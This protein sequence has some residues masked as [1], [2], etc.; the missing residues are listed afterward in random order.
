MPQLKVGDSA[1]EIKNATLVYTAN[2][3]TAF[4]LSKALTNNESILLAFHR[5]ASCPVCNFSLRQFQHE[6]DNLL[7]MG[8]RYVP[9][10][11]SS[12]E[13]MQEAYSEEPPFAIIAD[14]DM[15]LYKSYGLK[16]SLSAFLHP[17]AIGDGFKAV[18][19]ILQ[20]GY[21]FKFAPEKT[22]L[23]KPADFLIKANGEIAFVH[24]GKSLGDSISVADAKRLAAEV[25]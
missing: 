4:I 23:T 7:E 2:G 10:F 8:V 6:Y 25:C 15:K 18:N 11:H 22:I 3:E 16:P 13:N 14:P 9:V 12:V 21:R 19:S 5:Y 24:Y 1:P 17:K 20:P